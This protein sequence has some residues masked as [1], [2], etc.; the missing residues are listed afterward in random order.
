MFRVNAGLEMSPTLLKCLG[1][2]EYFSTMAILS[3]DAILYTLF[4]LSFPFSLL[5]KESS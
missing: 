1:L 3:D 2:I 4:I 5:S